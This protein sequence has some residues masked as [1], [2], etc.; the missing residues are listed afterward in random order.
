MMLQIIC[1]H[2]QPMNPAGYADGDNNNRDQL[3]VKQLT[4]GR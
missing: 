4:A 3:P 2:K 1:G